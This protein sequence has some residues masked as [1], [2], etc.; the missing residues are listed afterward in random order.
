MIPDA[1]TAIVERRTSGVDPS[2]FAFV[3]TNADLDVVRAFM[4]RAPQLLGG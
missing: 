1:V 3:A 2:A 4:A